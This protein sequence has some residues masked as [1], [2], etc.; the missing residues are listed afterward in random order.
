M[1][2]FLSFNFILTLSNVINLQEMMP[3]F[4][5][6]SANYLE[7]YNRGY[8]FST[9]PGIVAYYFNTLGRLRYGFCGVKPVCWD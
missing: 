3:R 6:A 1:G 9:E 5:D 4:K 8:G 2:A 7:V